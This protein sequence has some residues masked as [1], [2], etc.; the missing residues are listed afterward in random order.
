M[1]KVC[2]WS[3]FRTKSTIAFRYIDLPREHVITTPS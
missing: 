2:M 1:T 3:V